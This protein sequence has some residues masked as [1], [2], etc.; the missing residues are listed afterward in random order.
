[1][2][3]KLKQLLSMMVCSTLLVAG[4]PAEALQQQASSQD[5]SQPVPAQNASSAPAAA[6]AVA[7]QTADQL[8]ALVAPI[9][10]YPD[11]LVAQILA[12]ATLP[13]EVAYAEDWVQQ[14]SSFTG[15][16]L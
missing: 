2:L 15:T 1:M 10:L 4:A 13:D 12:A 5:A 8:D 9:A 14:N 3:T 6:P 7:P 16:A 11:A